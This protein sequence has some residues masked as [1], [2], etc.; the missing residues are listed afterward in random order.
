MKLHLLTL[1]ES[2]SANPKLIT[3]VENE[4]ER[5]IREESINYVLEAF[6]I[7]E[8]NLRFYLLVIL[9]KKMY[10]LKESNQSLTDII[11]VTE[12]I[13]LNYEFKS[14]DEKKLSK[15]Y[16]KIGLFTWPGSYPNFF[17][18]LVEL[19]K[20]RRKIGFLIFENFL[21]LMH[22]NIEI[23]E[24]R[25]NELKR[26]MV[27]LKDN[28]I[29]LINNDFCLEEVISIFTHLISILPKP[30]DF[31]IILEKGYHFPEKSLDFFL[32]AIYAKYND[33]GFFTNLV[34]FSEFIDVEPKMIECF[35]NLKD[36]LFCKN[37]QLYSYVF[38]GISK[39]IYS[40]SLSLQFWIIVFRKGLQDEMFYSLATQIL[41]EVIRVVVTFQD[42]DCTSI[43]IEDLESDVVTLFG[44][45]SHNYQSANHFFLTNYI[46]NIPRKY[47]V[48]LLKANKDK[49]TLP[50][51]CP[52]LKT[53]AF[54]L[55][56]NPIATEIMMQL[57]LNDKDSCKLI[58]QVV[59][60][61]Y[62]DRYKLINIYNSVKD[63]PFTEEA[64]ANIIL[65][66]EDPLFIKQ[67]LEGEMDLKKAHI[68]FYF[69]KYN[70]QSVAIELN[71]FFLFFLNQQPFD[72][73]FSII[74]LIYK[75]FT[76]PKEIWEKIYGSLDFYSLKDLN[77]LCID[78]LQKLNEEL[79]IPFIEKVFLRLLN[80]WNEPED[81]IE[82]ANTTKS[83]ISILEALVLKNIKTQNEINYTNLLIEF[84]KFTN[85]QI[86]LKVYSFHNRVKFNFETERMTL[87][88]LMCYN[89]FEMVDCQNEIISLLIECIKKEDGPLAFQKF[90]FCPEKIHKIS[91]LIK[92]SSMKRSRSLMKDLLNDIKG[93]PLSNLYEPTNKIQSQNL[94][95]GKSKK[96]DD[97]EF[98]FHNIYQ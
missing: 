37:L 9:E 51:N 56:N 78:L 50:L 16:A 18:I 82:L 55:D 97:G 28:L 95:T 26:A 86:L 65:K 79:Q 1:L 80:E 58:G 54:Y 29:Q 10:I 14:I 53:L 60:K 35:L 47:A 66:L 30:I 69:L 59:R 21:Y 22:N 2:L 44:L 42:D 8:H 88:L 70:P 41:Q 38:K 91:E 72:R 11:N 87:K 39:N 67:S 36:H 71:K 45:I 52:Y 7:D 63:R 64:I 81:E 76:V 74:A 61:Y 48:I 4:V 90:N 43:K 75:N 94:F 33:F 83:F 27:L 77:Y 62:L 98:V 49:S 84:L 17:N 19:I 89:S 93:K 40:F 20:I 25:R 5:I 96:N 32:E 23:D 73:S 24:N 15:L 31:K 46:N 12:F 6:K 68:I 13:L 3:A 92:N 34:N 57:D 85:P